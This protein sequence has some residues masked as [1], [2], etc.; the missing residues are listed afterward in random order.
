LVYA[1]PTADR[2]EI[3]A[4][5]KTYGL[6]GFH[7]LV[8][9]GHVLAKA[10][11]ATVTPEAVVTDAS[12]RIL[13]RGRIDDAVAEISK[14]WR[15]PSQHDLRDALAAILR[16]EAVPVSRTRAVG[17]YIPDLPTPLP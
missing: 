8:D 6:S 17:C 4:H 9:E 11:G 3:E 10:T 5:I 12:G 15:V 16:N 7:V 1:D 2:K 13:Y 14:P